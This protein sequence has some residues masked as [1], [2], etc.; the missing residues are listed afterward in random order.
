MERQ[1]QSLGKMLVKTF[2]TKKDTCLL[3]AAVAA[4][5]VNTFAHQ[6]YKAF[7]RHNCKCINVL[8]VESFA[9]EDLVYLLAPHAS[10]IQTATAKF[11][12][13]YVRPLVTDTMLDSTHYKLKVLESRVSLNTFHINRL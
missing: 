12:H 6:H 11:K 13:N 3:F 2:D 9:E 7:T 1:I 10:S 5:A 4:Y 8:K